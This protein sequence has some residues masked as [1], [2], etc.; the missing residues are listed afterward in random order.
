MKCRYTRQEECPGES[1]LEVCGLRFLQVTFMVTAT[2]EST[3]T[4]IHFFLYTL[5]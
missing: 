3:A 1:F 5:I 2:T 4:D